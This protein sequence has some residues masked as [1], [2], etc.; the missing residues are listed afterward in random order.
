M[1]S[2]YCNRTL[3]HSS[4]PH[5]SI[6]HDATSNSHCLLPFFLFDPHDETLNFTTLY[7]ILL[8]LLCLPICHYAGVRIRLAVYRLVTGWTARGSNAGGGEILSLLLT[9]PTLSSD[10]PT[11][12]KVGIRVKRSW[13]GVDLLPLLRAEVNNTKR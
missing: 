9:R 7:N 2:R 11:S 8:H 3:L 4:F 10:P 5:S 13:H 1:R 12:S 6:S